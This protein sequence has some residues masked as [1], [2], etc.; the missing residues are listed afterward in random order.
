L[1]YQIY[2]IGQG[3]GVNHRKPGYGQRRGHERA[4]L[5]LDILRI[6]ISHLHRA[7]RYTHLNARFKQLR[8]M[9]VCRVA[10]VCVGAIVS[11]AIPV[12]DGYKFRHIES[13]SLRI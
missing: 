12:P 6:S 1:R 11:L 9:G 5:C 8:V 13:P 10:N 4:S 2:G 3:C 7:T